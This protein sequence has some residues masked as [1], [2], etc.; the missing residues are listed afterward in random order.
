MEI[1]LFGVWKQAYF[2][3]ISKTSTAGLQAQGL[4][5]SRMTSK[6]VACPGQWPCRVRVALIRW[7]G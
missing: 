1:F 4:A 6:V 5:N 7:K 3:S 2:R